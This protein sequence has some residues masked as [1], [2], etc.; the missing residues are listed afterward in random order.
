M[1]D[2]LGA[3]LQTHLKVFLDAF[4]FAESG[5]CFGEVDG[6][7]F[8]LNDSAKDGP[9]FIEPVGRGMHVGGIE[10]GVAEGLFAV[11]IIGLH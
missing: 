8:G 10:S 1:E 5:F 4:D 6:V 3:V 2:G 9:R 7:L 11:G